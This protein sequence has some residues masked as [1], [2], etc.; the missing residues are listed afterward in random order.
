MTDT[1]P[2]YK[3]SAEHQALIERIAAAHPLLIDG[4]SGAINYALKFTAQHDPMVQ[5]APDADAGASP[6]EAHDEPA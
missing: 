5:Q 2:T 6:L 4:V 3:P 1:R